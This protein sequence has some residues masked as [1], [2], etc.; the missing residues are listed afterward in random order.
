MLAYLRGLRSQEVPAPEVFVAAMLR[1][2]GVPG[3]VAEECVAL[4]PLPL[5]LPDDS[6]IVCADA[7]QRAERESGHADGQPAPE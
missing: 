1:M 6:L 7:A 4:G 2:L 3:D 5:S